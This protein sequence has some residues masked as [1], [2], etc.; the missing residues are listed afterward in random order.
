[1]IVGEYVLMKIAK[2]NKKRYQS[3]GYQCEIGDEIMV[4][5]SDVSLGSPVMIDI[6]CDYC[7]NT[8]RQKYSTYNANK[9]KTPIDK[10]CCVKCQPLKAKESIKKKY[11]VDNIFEVDEFREK[12]K[13]TIFEKYGVDNI[14]QS[15]MI[16]E[17]KK[18]TCLEHFGVDNY[19]K[20][21]MYSEQVKATSLERYGIECPANAPEVVK[22]RKETNLER[23][24][25]EYPTQSKE[26]RE[27]MKQTNLKK[28]GYECIF[29]NDDIKDKIKQTLF[30]NG[31][32]ATSK[33]QFE[34]Y[35][36]LQEKGY[37]VHLNYPVG[38]YALDIALFYCDKKIDIEYDGWYWHQ[39]PEK[40]EQRNQYL[41]EDGWNIVRVQSGNL[42]PHK[43]YFDITLNR[44][45]ENDYK[46][47]L[48][49]LPDWKEPI[50][51]K[52]EKHNENI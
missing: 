25:V 46:L 9:K 15:Q 36:S 35:K 31:S 10:D 21:P 33:K 28:Y 40:D 18:Q 51:N 8:F 11:N 49:K 7:G 19:T 17:K 41:I 24:G 37:D 38:K 45:V 42:L 3:L 44:V 48:I 50:K 47:I 26:I 29:A 1:M 16:K 23:Y 34:L 2:Q 39:N 32:V 27:K 52:E 20:T 22:K 6:E 30:A 14:S 43:E 5:I 12:Y 13:K 4:K